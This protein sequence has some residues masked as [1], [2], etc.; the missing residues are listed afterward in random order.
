MGTA[1]QRLREWLTVDEAAGELSHAFSHK[2]S[3]ADVLRLA[4]D[5]QLTLSLYLPAKI[6]AR[7]RPKEGEGIGAPPKY[8]NI[9]GLCDVP[10]TGRGRLQIEH[11]YHWL[12]SHSWVPIDG[13]LGAVVEQGDLVC[14]LPPDRGETGLSPRP[15]SEFPQ[16]SVLAVRRTTLAEFAIKHA[17]SQAR[18]KEDVVKQHLDDRARVTLLVIIAALCKELK[19]DPKERGVA[20]RIVKMAEKLGASVGDDTVRRV[21]DQLDDAVARRET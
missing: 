16:A 3:A 13:P 2:V 6:R 17:Q 11:E 7:C 1:F 20:I 18:P 15:Q 8:K 21:L 12:R 9:E 14:Q 10:M 4:I 19:I 5:G